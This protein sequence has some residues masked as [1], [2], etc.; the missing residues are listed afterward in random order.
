MAKTIDLRTYLL[1][2]R[3]FARRLQ[4]SWQQQSAPLYAH[5]TQACLDHKWDEARRLVPDLDMTEVGT[6][7]RE[8]IQYMLLSCAVFG[9]STVKK[10]KPSFV[11]V[12][13][14]DTFLKQVT[15]NMLQY[16]EL[17]ATAQVQAEALQLIA[18][19]EAKT[20]ALKFDPSQLR[21][22]RGRWSQTGTAAFKA[23][24]GNSKVVDEQGRPEVVYHGTVTREDFEAFEES[25]RKDGI[26]FAD[27]AVVGDYMSG[28][29][30]E[31]PR[32]IPVFLKMENPLIVD[33]EDP[34]IR[35]GIKE[36]E[37]GMPIHVDQ[38]R[39]WA[40]RLARAKGHDGVIFK[41]FSDE[42]YYTPFPWE[43]NIYVV[44]D[45]KQIKSAI[46]NVG[47]FDPTDPRI[48]KWDEAKH[49]RDKEGQFASSGEIKRRIESN[50]TELKLEGGGGP[51]RAKWVKLNDTL[52]E[53][54]D[55]YM[56]AKE[57]HRKYIEGFD[58]QLLDLADTGA[59][60]DAMAAL[61]TKLYTSPEY[62]VSLDKRTAAA[63]VMNQAEIDLKAQTPAMAKE[64]VTNLATQ[65]AKRLKIDPSII[66]VVYKDGQEFTVGD[67][68][69]T[70]A[71]HYTPSTGR[72]ELN[73]GNIHYGNASG[74]KGIVA[75]EISH[76]IYHTLKDEAEKEFERYLAK[77]IDPH[78]SDKYTEWF[79]ER[80]DK[81]AA[82][83]WM[84]KLKPEY[85]VEMV[86]EFPA[87]AVLAQMSD[88]EIFSGIS[89]RMVNENG[90]SQY[91][92]SYWAKEAIAIR[93][94]GTYEI[95]I[96]ETIAEV[97][98]Y[99]TYPSSWH[100]PDQAPQPSSPWVKLTQAMHYWYGKQQRA[101]A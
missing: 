48:T 66:D 15:N 91:A 52:M 81:G 79:H 80:F 78:D 14:F 59:D 53:V 11:G 54:T 35:R 13:T 47:A 36:K 100:L 61:E 86:W 31:R 88:G 60:M 29:R 28:R 64:V 85:R 97:T 44:F 99:I 1:L 40:I 65:V 72:I 39:G 10:G 22:E 19:D 24:F 37:K 45:P 82:T 17:S 90:H 95:A 21:D 7:N 38:V 3:A 49:P 5:I 46:G 62:Y 51:E 42:K 30:D 77:A 56:D 16:L 9:A 63:K 6:E 27:K 101:R 41:N 58:K 92:K 26:Y 74:V 69:F 70:E 2:E 32:A 25:P 57:E 73:A 8:W 98:R 12:G 33:S 68:H 71:G 87:S 18:E 83:N 94:R 96:N 55:F 50:L 93:G 84:R 75:H 4:R 76:A 89:E 43:G 20:K 34:E 67:K 23:W